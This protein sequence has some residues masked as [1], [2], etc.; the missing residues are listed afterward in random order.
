MEEA[1]PSHDGPLSINDQNWS[2]RKLADMTE[3]PS[4][5]HDPRLC[6]ERPHYD[7]RQDAWQRASDYGYD[8]MMDVTPRPEPLRASFG[9]M[10]PQPTPSLL[11]AATSGPPLHA[12]PASSIS[13]EDAG[14]F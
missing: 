8:D 2:S 5:P 1:V 13:F 6:D 10:A 11:P 7:W 3:D 14:F 12:P 9:G 4:F